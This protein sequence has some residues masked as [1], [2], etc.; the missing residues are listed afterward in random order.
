MGKGVNI[1]PPPIGVSAKSGP[2]SCRNL[3][4]D[5]LSAVGGRLEV[6]VPRHY[7]GGEPKLRRGRS[8]LDLVPRNSFLSCLWVTVPESDTG[9][10]P[11]YGKALGRNLPKELGNLAPYVRKK[12]SPPFLKKGR[13]AVKWLPGLFSKNTGPCLTRKRMYRD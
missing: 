11:E 13:G 4:S 7:V 2:A 10:L 6:S 3:R 8:C 1:R 5:A 9:R 12:G